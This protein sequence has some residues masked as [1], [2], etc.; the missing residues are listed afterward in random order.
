MGLKKKDTYQR[1]CD[2]CMNKFTPTGKSS[3]L[4]DKCWK[5]SKK[6]KRKKKK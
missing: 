6:K 2:K 4:C 3:K 5:K 1:Y